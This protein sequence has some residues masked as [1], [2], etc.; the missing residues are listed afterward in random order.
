MKTDGMTRRQ[1]KAAETKQKLYETADQL[2][3]QHGIDGVSVDAIVAAAGLSKGAFYVHFESK[4]ALVAELITA[5]ADRVDMDYKAYL[6]AFP[7]DTPSAGLLL[8]L[9]EKIFDVIE[10]TIGLEKIRALY[11]VQLTGATLSQTAANY[12]RALYGMLADVLERGVRRGEFQAELPVD[13]LTR[14]FVLAMRG[15]TYEWCIRY[16][17]FDLKKQALSHF[18]LLLKGIQRGGGL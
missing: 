9:V 17:D 16:P 10:G 7:A 2:F 15:L 13:A 5:Y 11:K 6:E 1:E 4:D 14:H 18:A 12:N 3:T 8:A